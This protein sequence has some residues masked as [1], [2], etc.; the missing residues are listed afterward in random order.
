MPAFYAIP[1]HALPA[2]EYAASDD[3]ALRD[4]SILLATGV[5]FAVTVGVQRAVADFEIVVI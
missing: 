2:P 5:P 3:V 4:T 1:R